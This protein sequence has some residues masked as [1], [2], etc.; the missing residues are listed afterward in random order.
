MIEEPVVPMLPLMMVG[1]VLVM[2]DSAKAPYGAA[3]PRLT[4]GLYRC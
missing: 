1:P 4:C 2:P 3:V